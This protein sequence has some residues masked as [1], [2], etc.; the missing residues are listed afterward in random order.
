MKLAGHRRVSN[1]YVRVGDVLR[2]RDG[3][4]H[5]VDETSKHQLELVLR[6]TRKNGITV[7]RPK[8]SKKEKG[9]VA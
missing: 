3:T 6:L 7:W 9:A 1:G 2:F 5:Y 8:P 4:T